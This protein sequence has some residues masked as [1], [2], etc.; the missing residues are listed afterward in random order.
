MTRLEEI[1]SHPIFKEINAYL[2]GLEWLFKYKGTLG[3]GGVSYEMPTL[4]NLTAPCSGINL[5]RAMYRVN[6]MGIN[7]RGVEV[8]IEMN[9]IG[10]NEWETVFWGTCFSLAFFHDLI[11]GAL[12]IPQ[13]KHQCISV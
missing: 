7:V 10:I 11:H 13:H 1:R 9:A 4:V 2:F 6:L 5:D 12:G 8:H 3:G